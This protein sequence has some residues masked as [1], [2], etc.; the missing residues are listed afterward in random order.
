MFTMTINLL[1]KNLIEYF[2]MLSN[3][4]IFMKRSFGSESFL[5]QDD[6]L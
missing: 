5:N 6:I 2:Y 4:I 3:V 1:N